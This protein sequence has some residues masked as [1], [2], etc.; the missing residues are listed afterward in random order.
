MPL[1]WSILFRTFLCF[2]I[3][4]IPFAIIAMKGTGIDILQAGSRNPGFNNV[5]RFSKWRAVLTLIGDFGKGMAA[6]WL[7]HRPGDPLA[8][9]WLYGAA[10]IVGHCYSPFLKFRGGK[11]IATSGGVMLM[12]YPPWASI[13]LAFYTA[14]RVTGGKMKIVE[15]GMLASMGAWM[16]FTVLMAV[17]AGMQE[18]VY[19]AALTAFAGWRHRS[20][21]RILLEARRNAA[22]REPEQSTAGAGSR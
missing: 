14:A 3:G 21:F 16:L 9:A 10:A 13:C 4:S 11:G 1:D 6:I 18:A 2:A 20:N 5:L 12:L 17:F 19:A 7:V 22:L 8:L 15:A